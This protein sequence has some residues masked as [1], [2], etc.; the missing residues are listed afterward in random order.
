MP[1]VRR[2]PVK[3]AL[4]GAEAS[5][6]RSA[7]MATLLNCCSIPCQ[8][9]VLLFKSLFSPKIDTRV[10]APDKRLYS[11]VLA[12]RDHTGGQPESL[13]MKG[14]GTIVL[15][16]MPEVGSLDFVRTGEGI[17]QAFCKHGYVLLKVQSH[18]QE[19]LRTTQGVL[20][21]ATG[22]AHMPH[23]LRPSVVSPGRLTYSF[24]PGQELGGLP[25]CWSITAAK[26]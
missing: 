24:T 17:S 3:A 21:R 14:P 15:D 26:V 9:W 16:A 22:G 2:L 4:T 10:M 23:S 20:K 11:D 8:A 6:T 19:Q 7:H 25:G 5:D 12:T 1:Q 13:R 18:E